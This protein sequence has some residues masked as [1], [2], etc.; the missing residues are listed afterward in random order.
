MRA[1]PRSARWSVYVLVAIL[2]AVACAFLASWQFARGELRDASNALITNNYDADPVPLSELMSGT[3]DFDPGD[4]WHPVVV[5]GEYLAD[6]QLLARNRAEGGTSAY[7]VIVPLQLDDGRILAI[8]RGW[9]PPAYEGGAEAVPA[10][11]TGEVTVTARLRASEALPTSGRTAPE[12]QL[13]MIHVPS[14]AAQT[15]EQTITPV[16]AV[17]ASEE[18]APAERP[19]ALAAPEVDPGPHLSYAVQWILFAIMGFA[20]IGYMIRTEMVPARVD[21]EDPDELGDDAQSERPRRRPRKRR[22]DRDAEEEDAI[23]DRL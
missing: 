22:R 18:P 20:F 8:D 4:E 11:P 10:P 1:W 19:N 23:L 9:V 2:F 12:G 16:Y 17:M 13:P 3:D 15:G 7:E 21:D 14:V 5:T 6:D